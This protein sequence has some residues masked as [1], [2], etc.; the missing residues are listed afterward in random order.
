[1]PS[2]FLETFGCQM[3]V[4]DSDLL[5]SALA[6]RGYDVAENAGDADL[7]IVNTCSVREHAETRALA[8]IAQHAAHKRQGKR[9]RTLWVIGCMAERMGETL[10]KR[11][12]GV[13]RVVGARDFENFLF[14]L[15]S[16]LGAGRHDLRRPELL[17]STDV[18]RFVPI[19]RGCN[20]FCSYCVVPHV[21]GPEI[22]LSATAIEET[23][24][25]YVNNGTKE[26]T[27]L[28]QNVN[29]YHDGTTDFSA[30]LR[31]LHEIPGIAR[32]RFTTSHPKDLSENL[33]RTIAELPGLCRHIHLPVQ[34]GADR[35]LAV[36]NR[37][38][39]RADY[40][41]LIDMIKKFLPDADITTDAMVGFPSETPA[42]FLD[43]LSLFKQVRF[44]AAFM[45]MYSQR[46]NTA[47]AAMDNDV[48][49]P[50]KRKR[51]KELIDCQ[52]AITRELYQSMIGRTVSVLFTGRQDLR[53][54]KLWM[55]QDNG[56][57]RVLVACNE[58]LAGMILPVRTVHS[59]GMTLLCERE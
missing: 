39:T 27:L 2:F 7:I 13:D 56:C 12:K 58:T 35:V 19:M 36:M 4:A 46:E 53:R 44:T 9:R 23:V 33:V 50:E 18:S 5:A 41:R 25:A 3:N 6:S 34:S 20:N 16:H 11:I 40:L 21:R 48:P 47:A 54:E 1:M 26:I 42:D 22:S 17:Q 37:R 8:H 32:I 10:M 31:R 24:R 15:D 49:A 45:F 59:S 52:T 28:G 14:E 38:Y 51:L 57:K 55:G 43:T 30:L 29:S